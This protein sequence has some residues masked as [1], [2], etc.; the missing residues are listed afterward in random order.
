[1]IST[2]VVTTAQHLGKVQLRLFIN[3]V[4]LPFYKQP[5]PLGLPPLYMQKKLSP[6]LLRF[7][8]NL[9]PPF[10]EGGSELWGVWAQITIFGNWGIFALQSTFLAIY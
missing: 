4:S 9:N 2:R 3:W 5:P 1:M 7:F 10:I 8:Q 6:P